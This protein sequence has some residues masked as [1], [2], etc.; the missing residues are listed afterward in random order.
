MTELARKSQTPMVKRESQT[1]PRGYL[2]GYAR[3]NLTPSVL[4]VWTLA[5]WPLTRT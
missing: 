2:F 5:V 4:G 3:P 1:N